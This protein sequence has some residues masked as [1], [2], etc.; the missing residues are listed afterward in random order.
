MYMTQNGAGWD[1]YDSGPGVGNNGPFEQIGDNPG[2]YDGGGQ[3]GATD[4]L[5]V[6]V[7]NGSFPGSNF[8]TPASRM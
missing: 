6:N 2:D 8:V 5:G 3:L 4:V 1:D 7:P